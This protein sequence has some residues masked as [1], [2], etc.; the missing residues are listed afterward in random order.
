MEDLRN[1]QKKL[2]DGL[3]QLRNG[4]NEAKMAEKEIDDKLAE[5][6]SKLA[7]AESEYNGKLN[8]Y[9]DAL[10]Q[11]NLEIT[12]AKQKLSDAYK[13]LE[14]NKSYDEQCN[15]FLLYFD[16]DADISELMEQAMEV[17]GKDNI[18]SNYIRSNSPVFL[19]S[20]IRFWEHFCILFHNQCFKN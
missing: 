14:N 19:P 4:I 10:H 20:G 11:F 15:Q 1:N 12:D 16:K 13:E 2:E 18:I 5:A 8:E 17:L 3:T 6:S 7:D 9:Q